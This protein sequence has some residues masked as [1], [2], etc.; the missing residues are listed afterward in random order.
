[1]LL[2]DIFIPPRDRI[3]NGIVINLAEMR[4]YYFY[5]DG[6]NDYMVTAPI[7]VGRE[8][9]LTELGIYAIKSKDVSPTWFV[10]ESIR[11]EEPTLPPQVL[12]GPDNPLGGYIFRLSRGLYGIH[13]TNSPWGVGRR[14]SHG[15][16]RLYPEDMATLFNL[17]PAGT[18][19]RVIY[20]PIKIGYIKGELWLQ[21]FDDYEKL[22]KDSMKEVMSR[23]SYFEGSFGPFKIDR[24]ILE[25]S[26]MVRDG[27]PRMFAI[28]L[29]RPK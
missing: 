14:V 1:V 8:G 11:K 29:K 4:L 10:P 16:I 21:V 17:V 9:F 12:P 3:N 15:C 2:P 28:S 26:L 6:V 5:S 20:E 18:M 7:G 25:E 13:S 27:I 19:V 24:K 22:S 23:I